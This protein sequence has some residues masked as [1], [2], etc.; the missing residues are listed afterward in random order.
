MTRILYF[1]PYRAVDDLISS[2]VEDIKSPLYTK[3]S[4]CMMTLDPIDS[5][6]FEGAEV[7]LYIC[8]YILF[9]N[10]DT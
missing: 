6:G 5:G 8:R 4:I 3:S 1:S 9:M 2:D 10:D 7:M